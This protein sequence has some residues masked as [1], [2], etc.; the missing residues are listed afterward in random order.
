MYA[1]QFIVCTAHTSVYSCDPDFSY[2]L[3]CV[4]STQ[5]ELIRFHLQVASFKWVR[6][7]FIGN[8]PALVFKNM[9]LSTLETKVN[10]NPKKMI[11]NRSSVKFD[12]IQ[13]P[14]F[15][16]ILLDKKEL[17]AEKWD[18]LIDKNVYVQ[19]VVSNVKL[20]IWMS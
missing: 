14:T 5:L 12:F 7:L 2:V 10:K 1:N 6:T 11:P 16:L 4:W 15:S 20:I 3:F 9:W 13:R 19:Q 17:F 8:E 18:D